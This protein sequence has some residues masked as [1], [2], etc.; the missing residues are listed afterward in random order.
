MKAKKSFRNAEEIAHYWANNDCEH[1]GS[2]AN[3]FF[4]SDELFS[5]G[6]HF[7]LAKKIRDKAGNVAFV[8]LNSNSYSNTTNKHQRIVFSAIWHDKIE[9]PYAN[10]N[11][12]YGFARHTCEVVKSA[13]I[14]EKKA[15]LAHTKQGYKNIAEGAIEKFHLFNTLLEKAG[16]EPYTPIGEQ[17]AILGDPKAID[18]ESVRI[19]EEERIKR[20]TE[21]KR[22]RAKKLHEQELAF[23]EDWKSGQSDHIPY[24][25]TITDTVLRIK[26][27]RVETSRNAAVSVESAKTLWKLIKA[28]RDVK[29]HTVDGYTVISMNGVLRV[30]CHIINKSEVERI[31]AMLND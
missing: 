23:L 3:V 24:L 9:I 14:S 2:C 17:L 28:G 15:R 19:A 5:Y 4:D 29:G 20:Q 27:G 22:Q 26:D 1:Y 31:G 13:L 11:D 30:G 21:E 6:R 8:A 7:M 25:Q 10:I 12:R 18:L 16:I